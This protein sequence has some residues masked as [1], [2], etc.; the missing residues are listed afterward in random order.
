MRAQHTTVFTLP[1]TTILEPSTHNSLWIRRKQNLLSLKRVLY[2]TYQNRR[3]T[4]TI[5]ENH[6]PETLLQQQKIIPPKIQDTHSVTIE[7][8]LWKPT[9]NTLLTVHSS[10]YAKP[11]QQYGTF[12]NIH[13]ALAY[14]RMQYEQA[15]FIISH[16]NIYHVHAD[17]FTAEFNATH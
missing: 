9:A 11:I 15:G 4:M 7:T 1:D 12:R 3:R 6:N 14:Y 5:Q 10:L 16:E 17:M 2:N 8:S 13:H